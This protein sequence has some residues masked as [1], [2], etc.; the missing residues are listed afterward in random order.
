ME[1]VKAADVAHVPTDVEANRISVVKA[2]DVEH[3]QLAAALSESVKDAVVEQSPDADATQRMA[4]VSAAD[5][6]HVP[7]ADAKKATA[8]VSVAAR[9]RTI[10]R[11]GATPYLKAMIAPGS[12]IM[13]RDCPANPVF[14]L[15]EADVEQTPYGAA[16]R[17]VSR[18]VI[19]APG[20]LA[21]LRDAV[22]V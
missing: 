5:V 3:V 19:C 22:A 16:A 9:T 13:L 8:T 20:S 10:D 1:V 21:M 12:L 18:K 17:S 15:S 14:E 11:L 2:A 6:E 4:V 7:E